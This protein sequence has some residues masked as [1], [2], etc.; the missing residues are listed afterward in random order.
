MSGGGPYLRKR[1]P[2]R[3]TV[4]GRPEGKT[5]SVEGDLLNEMHALADALA[6]PERLGF[7]P[8]LSQTLRYMV[9]MTRRELGLAPLTYPET[10]NAEA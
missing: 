4:K 1:T 5:L 7:R 10:S 6:V 3:L 9:N 2:V 8:N